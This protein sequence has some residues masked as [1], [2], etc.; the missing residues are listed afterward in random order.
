MREDQARVGVFA[1]QRGDQRSL[2]P[3]FGIESQA[4]RLEDAHDNPRLVAEDEGIAHVEPIAVLGGG[5]LL[6]GAAA[7]QFMGHALAQH[8]LHQRRRRPTARAVRRRFLHAG[9]GEP[10]SARQKLEMV[11][12]GGQPR[13][14]N[15]AELQEAAFRPPVRGARDRLVGHQEGF[16]AGHRAAVLADH[17]GQVFDVRQVA[18]GEIADDFIGGAVGQHQH[19]ARLTGLLRQFVHAAHKGHH[20][21]QQGDD[22][23]EGQ[24]GHDGRFPTDGQIAEVVAQRDLADAK[25]QQEDADGDC[26]E[27]EDHYATFE[28]TSAT[29]TPCADQAGK[30]LPN[31]AA[32]P[33]MA[34]PHHSAA[35][36]IRNRAKKP[37]GKERPP[38][39][40]LITP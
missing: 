25:Q 6:G 32:S 28:N 23:R 12:P 14:F 5:K 10:V 4:G 34:G 17:L 1:E 3:D 20:H 8:G 40:Q 36:G 31:S 39:P 21:G 37:M 30:K 35:C 33:P 22:G 11:D 13:V 2:R 15:A 19:V 9:L 27:G 38:I 29:F 16:A 26:R 18:D 7:G 24:R